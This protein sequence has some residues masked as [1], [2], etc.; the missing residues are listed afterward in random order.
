MSREVSPSSSTMTDPQSNA[1][2]QYAADLESARSSNK[3]E[4]QQAVQ[5]IREM[6]DSGLPF[7]TKDALRETMQQMENIEKGQP[8]TVS[9]RGL[10]GTIA[11]FSVQTGEIVSDIEDIE[12]PGVEKFYSQA[13][14]QYETVEH[15]TALDDP[16]AFQPS[17]AYLPWKI[18]HAIQ[19]R[20][21]TTKT[22]IPKCA[23][24]PFEEVKEHFH[25][26]RAEWEAAKQ[27]EEL[28]AILHS[29]DIPPVRKIVAFACSTMT[30]DDECRHRSTV[31]HALIL[32]LRDILAKRSN[33]GN[34]DTIACYAQDPV[35][36]DSDRRVLE[37]AGIAVLDDPKGFL[38]MD[39]E[40][41]VLSLAPD[42]PVRQITADLTRPAM[43]VWDK[44]VDRQSQPPP[45]ES[46]SGIRCLCLPADPVS[47][48]VKSMVQSYVELDFPRDPV[49]FGRGTTIY[50]RRS[51]A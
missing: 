44:V 41:V 22:V 17:F 23:H 45:A 16:M 9:V 46:H 39:E 28:R 26:K 25:R 18:V 24:L 49:N 43:M 15:L 34:P 14:L 8:G 31:Q 10:D 2:Q 7:F 37:E 4:M 29:A 12:R 40:T 51:P 13:R 30:W 38:E 21:A 20:D 47:P 33:S 5:K 48:R 27:C 42:I 19:Y 6:Y 35:Y 1:D 3:E 36:T 50:I 11:Q 32:T